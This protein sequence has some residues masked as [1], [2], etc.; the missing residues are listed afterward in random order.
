MLFVTLV[1]VF[2]FSHQRTW[3]AIDGDRIVTAG[4]SNRSQNAFADKFERFA[5]ELK[6]A[7]AA[8][9]Q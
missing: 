9:E 3:V 2:F 7:T 6:I 8:E 1:A 5:T 4:N